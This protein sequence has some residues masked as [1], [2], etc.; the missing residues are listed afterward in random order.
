MK[1][2]DIYKIKIV[3]DPY[4]ENYKT[5]KTEKLKMV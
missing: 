2:K 5:H 3:Q 4:T 1:R